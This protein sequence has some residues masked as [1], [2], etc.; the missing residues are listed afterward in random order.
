MGVFRRI[1][2]IC[3]ANPELE[4]MVVIFITDGQ[5]GFQGPEPSEEMYQEIATY[6]SSRPGFSIKYL[7]VGFSRDHDAEF[8]NR[9]ANFGNQRGNFI[10][11]DSYNENW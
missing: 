9:I 4:E 2:K 8:M 3:D 11:I 10:F 6:I 7:A 1:V 5:D